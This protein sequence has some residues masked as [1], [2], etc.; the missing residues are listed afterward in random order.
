[1]KHG[2]R[3]GVRAG[4]VVGVA[5]LGA[6]ATDSA[7]GS[8]KSGAE[9]VIVPVDASMP[10]IPPAMLPPTNPEPT[11]DSSDDADAGPV[12][13]DPPDG[14]AGGAS[15]HD[16]NNPACWS[17]MA[18]SALSATQSFFGG[19][20]D[21]RYVYLT[22]TVLSMDSLLRLDT[23]PEGGGWQEFTP[24]VDGGEPLGGG[25]E[26]TAYD[27][28]YMYFVPG[29]GDV[30]VTRYDTQGAFST[31]ASW[32]DFDL[33]E[34]DG[35]TDSGSVDLYEATDSGGSDFVGYQGAAFDG[36]YVYLVPYGSI[37]GATSGRVGRYDTTASFGASA[38]WSTFDITTKDPAAAGFSGATF[39][40][41][42]LY[43]V[44]SLYTAADGGSGAAGSL[45]VQFDTT[46]D[47]GSPASWTT[48][49]TTAANPFAAGFSGATFDGRYVYY[50]P[51]RGQAGAFSTVVARFDTQ[52]SFADA[53]AWSA[54]DTSPLNPDPSVY[55]WDYQGAVFDGRYVYFVPSNGSRLLRYDTESAFSATTAWTSVEVTS[56]APASHGDFAGAIF[57]GQHIYFVS[58]GYGPLTVFDAKTPAEIPAAP[59][60]LPDGYP[61]TG[62]FF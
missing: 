23:L 14:G 57:D 39:D 36:R 26:G 34:P 32:T 51:N 16:I 27:G 45:A 55:D 19:A 46:A 29:E 53:A 11:D 37:S 22:N 12:P 13:C 7:C 50:A 40:G 35:G 41:R 5:A 20:F 28:R 9:V 61:G 38:S 58:T 10:T 3:S 6:A 8:S 62:S 30:F 54:F 43:L 48:F 31:A 52:G 1:M 25:Y 17:T 15:Y 18:T 59:S 47:F 24:G 49:D 44:P 21:G 42:Y 4:L 60:S 56:L 33:A 2:A